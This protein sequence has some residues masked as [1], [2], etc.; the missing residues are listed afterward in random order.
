MT[1]GTCLICG[2][3]GTTTWTLNNGRKAAVVELCTAHAEPLR[4]VLAA[5]GPRPDDAPGQD[6][7]PAQVRAGW[8]KKKLSFEPL[9]WTPPTD[10]V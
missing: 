4:E 2:A 3:A 10:K 6:L 7:T 8:A 1:A 5:A 9:D